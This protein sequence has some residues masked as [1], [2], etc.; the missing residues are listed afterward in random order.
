SSVPPGGLTT[1]PVPVLVPPAG[2]NIPPGATVQGDR[3]N[4]FGFVGAPGI[5]INLAPPAGA[6]GKLR[7]S[8][9]V[10]TD[11]GRPASGGGIIIQPS[12][13]GSALVEILRTRGEDNTYGIFANGS[14][15]TGVISVQVRDSVVG[16]NV[17]NG[18]SAFTAAGHSTTSITLDRSSSILNGGAGIL[19]QGAV[20]F[21]TLT[22]STVMS[23]VTGLS[24]VNG[25]GTFSYQNNRLTG[26]VTDGAPTAVFTVKESAR[27]PR[28]AG[29]EQGP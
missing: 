10:I 13:S 16:S 12:G 4:I 29:A 22:D 2:I 1:Y 28:R 8:D 20:G 23:N 9:S 11:N 6:T 5:G 19:A 15:S 25:G 17:V 21:V 24:T 26:N 27:P 3:C 7:V 14:G 18:V